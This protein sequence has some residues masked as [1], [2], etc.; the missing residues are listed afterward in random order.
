MNSPAVLAEFGDV[1]RQFGSPFKSLVKLTNERINLLAKARKGLSGTP[2]QKKRRY[3]KIVADTYLEYA[4]GIAPL[5]SDTESVAEAFAQFNAE[6]TGA[7]IKPRRTKVVG[8][9]ESTVR[10]RQETVGIVADSIIV[11]NSTNTQETKFRVQ[12]VC[13]MNASLVA[14]F[15]SNQR[16]LDLLGFKPENIL[17]AVWEAVPW[18]FLIDYFTNVGDILQASVCNTAAV[19]WICKTVST[20]VTYQSHTTVNNKLTRD[21]AQA[22]G[23]ETAGGGGGTCGSW[24]VVRTI[25]DRTVPPKLTIPNLVVSVPTDYAKY[26]NMA[27]LVLG[28]QK[29]T[30]QLA[31]F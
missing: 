2:K 12:Y 23:Y 1:L 20:V 3:S 21:R 29:E 10:E 16:L 18:S 19:T 27:A 24:S 26:A 4:F 9:G 17:P 7:Y 28:R 31:V 5:I 13:G 11:Y 30:R 6:R 8:Q 22:F 25:L 15:G 14:D